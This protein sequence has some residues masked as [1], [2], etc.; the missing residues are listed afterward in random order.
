M[1][2]GTGKLAIEEPLLAPQ[3]S[4]YIITDLDALKNLKIT[5]GT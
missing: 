2:A 5:C 3:A 1:C 4:T